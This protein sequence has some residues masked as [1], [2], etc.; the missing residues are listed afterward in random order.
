MP[1]RQI[2]AKDR[3]KRGRKLGLNAEQRS[4]RGKKAAAA[5][6][7][8]AAYVRRIV[9]DAPQ[10]SD[11]DLA[12]LRQIV[13]PTS[14]SYAAGIKAGVRMAAEHLADLAAQRAS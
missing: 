9:R 12:A 6:H 11:E 14:E 2:V 10:L 13:G 4:E 3:D 1:V 7:S 5:S 8:I